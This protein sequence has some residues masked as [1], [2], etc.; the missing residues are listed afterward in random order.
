MDRLPHPVELNP[1]SVIDD[2][3]VNLCQ[4]GAEEPGWSG[5]TG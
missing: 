5:A 2:G 3:V 1:I 4:R